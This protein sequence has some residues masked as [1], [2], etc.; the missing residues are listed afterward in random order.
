MAKYVHLV[1][2]R[3]KSFVAWKLEHIPRG[4]NEKADALTVVAVS[5]P[6]KEQCSSLSITSRS[7]QLLLAG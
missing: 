1:K 7:R 3:L 6:I 4:S 5:L 2:L